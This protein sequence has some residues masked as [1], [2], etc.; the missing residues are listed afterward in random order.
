MTGDL[1]VV[2]F[3]NGG[4]LFEVV[5]AVDEL[6]PAPLVDAERT[7]NIVTGALIGAEELFGFGA[8]GVE[9]GEVVF[10]GGG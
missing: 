7:E 3:A 10:D 4:D 6:E 2:G 5:P 9:A 1:E 8:E